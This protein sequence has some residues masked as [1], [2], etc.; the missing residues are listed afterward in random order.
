MRKQATRLTV[1]LAACMAVPAVSRA[2]S[3]KFRVRAD[4]KSRA[5]F[6]SDAPLETMVGKTS[7]VSGSLMVDPSDITKTKGSFKVPVAS[8]RTGSDLRDEHLRGDGWLDAKKYPNIHFEIVEVLPG[9]RGS[10]EL[11]P[12]KTS[13]VQVKGKFTVHGVTQFVTAEGTVRWADEALGI[14]ADFTVNLEDH[15]VSVPTIV[16]LKVAE[17]IDVSVDLRAVGQSSPARSN[18]G[19]SSGPRPMKSS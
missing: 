13:K 6:V 17:E 3:T 19:S 9:K 14:T 2:D 1:V 15:N 8:L 10:P 7:K 11:K 18:K 12:N 16:Q 4:G 5:T